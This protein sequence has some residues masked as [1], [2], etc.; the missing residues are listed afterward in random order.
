VGSR[1]VAALLVGLLAVVHAQLWVGRGSVG[2]V[3]TCSA[4]STSRRRQ[5]QA[6]QANERLAAEVRDLQE[7]LEMVEEKARAELGMV[8]P[9]E[10]YV[11]SS[12]PS[13]AGGGMTPLRIALLGAE[14]TGKTTLCEALAAHCGSE[15]IASPSSPRCCASGARAKAARRARGTPGH[16]AGAGAA[17]RRRRP[18]GRHR[19][20]RH[21]RADGRHLRR[22]AV[23][24]RPAVRFAL[25]RQRTYD[26]TLVTGLDLP[27]V[28]TACS[29]TGRTRASRWMPW[30]ARLQRR[31]WLPGGVRQGPQRLRM[32]A[33][34]GLAGHAARSPAEPEGRPGRESARSA[35]TRSASTGCSSGWGCEAA[36][37]RRGALRRNPACGA[38][39]AQASRP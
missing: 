28:P 19:D 14:S 21:H 16:R 39:V 36:P 7:G 12:P 17:G 5:R 18:P 33:R 37:D 15:A 4:S 29:A 3:G 8:K 34:A 38:R 11:R 26:A 9:N 30:C 22:D 27:W 13:E 2:S 31:A 35:A 23:R 24:G 10:I 1:V 20:R 32:P 25:E 6:Q